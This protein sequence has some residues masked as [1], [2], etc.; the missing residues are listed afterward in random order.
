MATFDSFEP[1]TAFMLLSDRQPGHS[2]VFVSLTLRVPTFWKIRECQ[3][4]LF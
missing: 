4:I 2:T 3:G 1:L